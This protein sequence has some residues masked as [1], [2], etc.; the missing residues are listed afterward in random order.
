MGY[1][2]SYIWQIRQQHG[3]GTK[4]LL[5]PGVVIVIENADGQVLLGKRSDNNLWCTIGGATELGDTVLGTMQR[6]LKE[7]TNLTAE[8]YQVFGIMSDP[9][10]AYI[11][12]E[13]GD[14]SYGIMT[15]FHVTQTTGELQATDA[16]H[17]HFAW[18]APHEFPDADMMPVV[19]YILDMF[20]EYKKSG[21]FQLN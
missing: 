20:M 4:P 9:N 11:K 10:Q 18:F 1:V 21:Q 2:G 8:A 14:E 15:L 19:R 16:E 17:T 12:Y 3:W 13:H 7:E 6:E 5:V